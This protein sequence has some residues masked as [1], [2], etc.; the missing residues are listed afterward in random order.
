MITSEKISVQIR[1]ETLKMIYNAKA[2]HIGGAFSMADILAVLY[3]EILNCTPDNIHDSKRDRFLLSKG[4][5]C[6]SL[7]AVLALK[8]FYP[9]SDLAKYGQNNTKFL[10][11][12]S[13]KI[14]GI[15]FSTGSLGHALSVASGIALASI[16]RNIDHFVYVLLSDGELDEG[17]NWEALLFIQHHKLVNLITIIDYNQIQSFGT[18]KD[19]LELEPLKEKFMS[20]NFEV[21]EIDGHNHNEIRSAFIKSRKRSSKPYII[22]ANTIKG[23]GVPFMENELLWHYK[24]PTEEQFNS[25]ISIL[26]NSI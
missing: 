1:V 19:V 7:Y 14:T 12:A 8:G 16:R 11:H 15:E 25:A 26:N 9:L 6:T 4:H 10:A 2:S 22:I 24:S 17:S 18:I 13:H 21:I 5:A 23:K 3:Q 20:F